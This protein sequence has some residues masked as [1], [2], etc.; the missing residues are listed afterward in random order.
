MSHC[1]A[2]AAP[3]RANR[4]DCGRRRQNRYSKTA[5][6]RAAYAGS[7][8]AVAYPAVASRFPRSRRRDPARWLH[9]APCE[10]GYTPEHRR[11]DAWH[12]AVG[13]RDQLRVDSRGTMSGW[14]VVRDRSAGLDERLWRR[15]PAPRPHGEPWNRECSAA[16]AWPWRRSSGEFP[17]SGTLSR[18]PAE[19]DRVVGPTRR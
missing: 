16:S 15:T 12:R 6:L 9:N 5:A 18:R 1:R 4:H 10:N 19:S 3:A 7:R 17:R 2:C 14:V 8:R 13:R 11:R